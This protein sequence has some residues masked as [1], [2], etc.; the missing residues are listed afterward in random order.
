MKTKI[1]SLR[2]LD[3]QGYDIR[4]RDGFLTLYDGQRR[5][6]TKNPKIMGNMYLLKLNIV[7]H[8]FLVKNNDEEAWLWNRRMRHQSAHIF[9]D[10]ARESCDMITS[11]LKI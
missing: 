4:L 7:K 5:L 11:F 1:L 10:M 8:Y 9:H 2:K 3:S 6:L